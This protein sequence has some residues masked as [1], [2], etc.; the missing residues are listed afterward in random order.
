[1]RILLI[2]G[3]LIYSVNL[4]AEGTAL[5]RNWENKILE[6]VYVTFV[7]CTCS[8]FQHFRNRKYFTFT[9][10]STLGVPPTLYFQQGKFGDAELR[11]TKQ[12]CGNFTFP[13]K[14]IIF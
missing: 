3:V 14:V 4:C 9:I 13:F 2:Q 5:F 8:Y 6:F 1:M 12:N 10:I 7:T 11:N